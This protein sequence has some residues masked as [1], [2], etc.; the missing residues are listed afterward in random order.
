MKH[1]NRVLPSAALAG[2]ASLSIA[3][4]PGG[5]GSPE[6]TATS[7]AAVQAARTA[8][9]S[10]ATPVP[11]ATALPIL[12]VLT[13]YVVQSGDYPM[14]I[15]ENAGVPA[16]EREAWIAE[17]LALNGVEA[18]SLQIGQTLILP[19]YSNGTLPIVRSD[20][21]EGAPPAGV[22]EPAETSPPATSTPK[23]GNTP[24]AGGGVPF[25]A[26]PPLVGFITP[27]ATPTSTA[28]PGPTAT[29]TAVPPGDRAWLT[30]SDESAK[31]YY[32]DLDSGWTNIPAE[33]LLAF[34]SEQELLAIW[35]RYRTK[36]PDSVC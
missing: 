23:P 19:P 16:D 27:T 11:S 7:A 32:C 20:T 15:A 3:C 28:T 26:T 21:I 35:G 25:A 29:S 5:S 22:L 34:D 31:Y 30:S 8:T 4:L 24:F 36:A 13:S 33:K 1:W 10:T 14:L 18:T 2:L 9:L 12:P 6:P 17:M